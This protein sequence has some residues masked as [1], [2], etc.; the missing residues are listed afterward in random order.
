MAETTISI[1]EVQLKSFI[2][3]LR[4]ADEELRKKIDFGYS[5][6]G[7]IVL[8]FEIRPQWNNPIEYRQYEFAKIRYV[9]SSKLWKL[10]WLR[11]SGKWELYDPQ[12]ENVN[13]QVLL[14]EIKDDPH[15]CFFG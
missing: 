4:P 3:S 14:S 5:W 7:Q 8:L 12:P 11:A 6:D 15:H 1:H 9:K 2:N 10:Y 13:L